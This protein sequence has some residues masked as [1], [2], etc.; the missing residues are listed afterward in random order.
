MERAPQTNINISPLMKSPFE[1]NPDT[2]VEIMRFICRDL[3]TTCFGHTISE[4]S[5]AS[6]NPTYF[7]V[8]DTESRWCRT[9]FGNGLDFSSGMIGEATSLGAIDNSAAAGQIAIF[10]FFLGY[11]LS[12]F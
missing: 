10:V 5:T 8:R 11:Y 6:A 9:A 1:P 7:V 12:L 3:W 4:A 2:T